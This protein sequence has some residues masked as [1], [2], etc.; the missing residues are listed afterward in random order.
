MANNSEFSK[1]KPVNAE[2][3]EI[4]IGQGAQGYDSISEGYPLKWTTREKNK[5]R[6]Y[7]KSDFTFVTN[8]YMRSELT[9]TATIK[10]KGQPIFNSP[11]IST[12][13]RSG[14]TSTSINSPTQI[15]YVISLSEGTP[16]DNDFLL[17]AVSETNAQWLEIAVDYDTN[18]TYKN[19]DT[20]LVQA[21]LGDS[22]D[23]V[24]DGGNRGA[25]LNRVRESLQ[26]QFSLPGIEKMDGYQGLD[27]ATKQI[28]R[29]YYEVPSGE[30]PASNFT[31][32]MGIGKESDFAQYKQIEIGN[33]NT[34]IETATYTQIKIEELSSTNLKLV[35]ANKNYQDYYMST[36]IY[37]EQNTFN[38]CISFNSNPTYTNGL[39]DEVH[40][41]YSFKDPLDGNYYLSNNTAFIFHIKIYPRG[42]A[43]KWRSDET[44]YNNYY[45][46]N[47]VP[48]DIKIVIMLDNLTPYLEFNNS[49]SSEDDFILLESGA[50]N[51]KTL[52]VN[53]NMQWNI[54][55]QSSTDTYNVNDSEAEGESNLY[56]ESNN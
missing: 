9:R 36:K 7:R 35:G 22:E 37:G 19:G 40:Y 46:W 47:Y 16:L 1:F 30:S 43:R 4:Y 32:Y 17:E 45:Q 39:Q 48:Y 44:A 20:T 6:L 26:Y 21:T 23:N 12:S 24:L 49:T 3:Q 27:D 38:C 13:L 50:N 2:G 42:F 25:F 31:D 10:Q 14:N 34:D 41:F 51:T 28:F 8:G 54:N 11:N 52:P 18:D 15:T 56:T 55:G 5:G 33:G 53:S 29:M